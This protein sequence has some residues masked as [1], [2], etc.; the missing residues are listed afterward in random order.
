M[1]KCAVPPMYLYRPCDCHKN[2]VEPYDVW[3]AGKSWPARPLR[4]LKMT[5]CAKHI[6]WVNFGTKIRRRYIAY[7]SNAKVLGKIF[8]PTDLF[9]SFRVIRYIY[10][11]RKTFFVLFIIYSTGIF[12]GKIYI[13][14]KY[15][16]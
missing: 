8:G 6:V 14:A 4:T 13:L 1:K 7:H 15:S 16:L 9:M 2:T 3:H 10:R 11:G 5:A 12:Y